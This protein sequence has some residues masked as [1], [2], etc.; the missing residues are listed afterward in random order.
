[1]KVIN[2]ARRMKNYVDELNRR[3]PVLTDSKKEI[4][5]AYQM[6]Q[7]CYQ[8]GGKLLIAGNGGSAADSEHMAGELMKRFQRPRPIDIKFAEKLRNIDM[9]RGSQLAY[10]LEQPLM[11]IP[12]VAHES[13]LTAYMNDVDSVGVFAQQLLG[14][15]R[16]GDVFL[17][18]STSGNSQNI[19]NATVVAKA[20]GIKVIALTGRNGGELADVADIAVKVPE[21]ET[22]KIQELHLPVYHCWCMMLEEYFFGDAKGEVRDDRN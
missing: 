15:G 20:L 21:D 14:Y 22:Y 19:L 8:D 2:M 18:I 11:A 9:K 3:Y 10:N 4:L 13:L 17:G 6:M 1:M 16:E 5:N 12:L 7:I